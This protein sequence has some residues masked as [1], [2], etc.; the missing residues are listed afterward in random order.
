MVNNDAICV[1]CPSG[2]AS[3]PEAMLTLFSFAAVVVSVWSL[4][5]SR[6]ASKE[7]NKLT[8]G[9]L[10]MQLRRS[11]TE[12]WIHMRETTLEMADSPMAIELQSQLTASLMESVFNAYDDACLEYLGGS[13]DRR[14][15]LESYGADVEA[16]MQDEDMRRSAGCFWPKYRGLTEV[17]GELKNGGRPR[18]TSHG[19]GQ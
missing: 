4:L 8:R 18:R 7:A 6:A 12:A 9:Q 19:G 1:M 17:Y 13:I 10:Q 15:F 5:T 14:W 11:I 2:G 3:V 16:L